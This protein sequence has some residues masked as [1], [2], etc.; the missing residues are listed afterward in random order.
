MYAGGHLG[1]GV[2]GAAVMGPGVAPLGVPRLLRRGR[3]RGERAP[4]V[5][6]ELAHLAGLPIPLVRHAWPT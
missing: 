1:R 3:Q 4:V 5:A 6:L 2:V